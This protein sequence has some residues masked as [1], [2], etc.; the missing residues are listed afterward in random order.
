MMSFDF[1]KALLVLKY[2]ISLMKREL[3]IWTPYGMSLSI[4]T[5]KTPF[6]SSPLIFLHHKSVNGVSCT[7]TDIFIYR[8]CL[9]DMPAKVK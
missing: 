1:L 8:D 6:S 9:M 2:L 7:K 5:A 4:I 3:N